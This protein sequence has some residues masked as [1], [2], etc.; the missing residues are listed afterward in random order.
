MAQDSSYR[1][2]VLTLALRV[3]NILS[4]LPLVIHTQGIPLHTRIGH[5]ILPLH[6]CYNSDSTVCLAYSLLDRIHGILT[7]HVVLIL[8]ATRLTGLILLVCRS[9]ATNKW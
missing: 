6:C 5:P 8:I 3:Q 4:V 7:A 9:L 1:S 2:L